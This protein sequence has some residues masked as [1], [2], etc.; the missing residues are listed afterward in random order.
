MAAG[1][2]GWLPIQSR[3]YGG[4]GAMAAPTTVAKEPT[5]HG[6]MGGMKG[7][8]QGGIYVLAE[9][10]KLH[11]HVNTVKSKAAKKGQYACCIGPS[12]EW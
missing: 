1:L 7:G 11:R 5:M 4:P 9:S 8:M 12:C 10:K 2:A 3:P 6:K